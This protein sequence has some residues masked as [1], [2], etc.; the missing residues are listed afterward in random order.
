MS[1]NNF[2]WVYAMSARCEINRNAWLELGFFLQSMV[3]TYDI[4]I[5][6]F[7]WTFGID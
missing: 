6:V 5:W 1:N 3:K 7:C 2:Y 4:N